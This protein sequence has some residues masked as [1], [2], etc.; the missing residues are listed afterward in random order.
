MGQYSA[1]SDELHR[2]NR[3]RQGESGAVKDPVVAKVDGVELKMSEFNT[4]IEK[5]IRQRIAALK[6][7]GLEPA[8]EKEMTESIRQQYS[9]PFEQL[10]FLEQWVSQELL[11]Q[12]ALQWKLE[13]HPDYLNAIQ[14]FRKAYLG[15]MLIRDKTS[16]DQISDLDLKNYAQANRD[17][18]GITS[19]SANLTQADID[20]SKNKIVAAYKQ[21]KSQELQQL[22]QAEMLKRHQVE[23]KREAFSEGAK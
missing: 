5:M 23:I 13:Q 19:S 6:A 22:F 1:V 14:D 9:A 12:E 8:K 11:Y 2:K 17:K 4:K 3:Q 18:L 16:V 10:K 15:Q 21:D 20:A 7:Q